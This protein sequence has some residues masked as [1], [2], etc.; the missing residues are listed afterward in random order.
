MHDCLP[1]DY[2]EQAVPRC[3]WT[4]KGDVWK[5]IVDSRKSKEIDVYTCY[6][7]HGI[8]VIIKR[9]NRNILEIPNKDAG[10][11]KFEDYFHNHKNLMNIIEYE[12]L[13]EII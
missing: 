13:I 4:W 2:F 10:S 6:A 11:L 8:G 9:P 7:D 1:N 12:N 3:Q 5:A